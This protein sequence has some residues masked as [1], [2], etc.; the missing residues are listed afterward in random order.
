MRPGV[1][2]TRSWSELSPSGRRRNAGTWSAPAWRWRAAPLVSAA[3][4]RR[5]LFAKLYAAMSPSL[6]RQFILLLIATTLCAAA[7][8]F[9]IGA[10]LPFLALLA[11]PS[12]A[13]L[14]EGVR[15]ALASVGP[16]V[17]SAAILLAG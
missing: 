8:A 14:P 2:R 5:A 10:T 4:T 16:P 7:E 13:A 11:D 17:A 9:A 15:S 6:R 12:G 1:V 3:M